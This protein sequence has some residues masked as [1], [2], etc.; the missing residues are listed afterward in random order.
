MIC[1]SL[2]CKQVAGRCGTMR[3]T[4]SSNQAPSFIRCSRRVL[5]GS[6]GGPGDSQTQFLVE[7]VGSGAQ[8]SPPLVGEE[9]TAT[10]AV[11]LEAVVQLFR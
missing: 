7:H 3:R 5:S 10:G 4:E 11:D 6:E 9:A 2:R 8:Q 1:Q